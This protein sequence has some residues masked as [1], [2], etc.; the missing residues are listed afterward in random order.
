MPQELNNNSYEIERLDSGFLV[1]KNENLR[2]GISTLEN[3][4]KEISI[5]FSNQISLRDNLFYIKNSK[6]RIK[7]SVE[8]IP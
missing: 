2:V 5:I 6:V 3:L 4:E 1:T 7:I 8:V